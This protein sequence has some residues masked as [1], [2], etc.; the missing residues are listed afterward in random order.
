MESLIPLIINL[1]IC[2]ILTLIIEIA[3][4]L[5]LKI[6]GIN[7]LMVV[8]VNIL[9]NPPAAFTNIVFKLPIL[10]VVVMEAAIVGIEGLIY[11][12]CDR[13]EGFDIPKPF[14]KALIMNAASYLIGL[15]L[16]FLPFWEKVWD[17]IRGV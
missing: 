11:Y 17:I 6:R 16:S 1:A 7:L 2:L 9:T 3:V 5:M 13:R 14:L 12:I 8:L 15:G 10:G 4:A